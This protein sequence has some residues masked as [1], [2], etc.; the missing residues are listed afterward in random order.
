MHGSLQCVRSDHEKETDA[1]L[2]VTDVRM[3]IETLP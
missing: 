2:K 1:K 3:D